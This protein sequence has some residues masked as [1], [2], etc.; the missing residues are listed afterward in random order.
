[1]PLPDS[2]RPR[3]S[4]R[5]DAGRTVLGGG[6]IVPDVEVASRVGSKGDRELQTALGARVPQFRN[7]LVDYALSLKVAHAVT[8]PDF[9]VTPAMREELYRRLQARG[10]TVDRTVYEGAAP[11]VTRA[12]GAQIARYAF[13]PR[14]EFARGLREDP[15]LAKALAL[16]EGVGTQQEL[17]AR[18]KAGK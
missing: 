4:F 6:G 11:L 9:V 16:L 10:V 14:A 7:V 18:A 17:L 12:L 15:T 5:T 13:G 8:S 2:T 1:V 3:P